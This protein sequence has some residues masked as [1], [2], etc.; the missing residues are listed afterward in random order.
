MRRGYKIS[1]N[2]IGVLLIF[3]LIISASYWKYQNDG[4]HEGATV[5]VEDGLSI[6]FLSGNKISING[7]EKKYAFSVTNNKDTK[8]YYYI[9][10]SDIDCNKEDIRYSL[11]E[12]ENKLNI[13][14]TEFPI[15]DADLASF[16]EIAPG[17]THTYELTLYPEVKT[18]LKANI[19]IRVEDTQKENFAA[20]ILA[21]NE[22]KKEPVTKIGEEASTENEG[23]I[24]AADDNGN[25]YYFRGA[26]SNNYVQFAN[27][28]WRIVK[29]NGDGSIKIILEDY[30]EEKANF[31]DSNSENTIDEKLDFGISNVSATLKN[32]YQLNL[33][34]YEK[35]IATSKYCID[36]SIGQ[37]DGENTY[38]LAYSRLL[39]DYNQVNSCLG[40]KY[41]SRIGL[42]TA[43]EAVF[44]GAS[45]NSENTKF[46]L[47]TEG[48]DHSW[49]T[50]TP[51]SSNSANVTFFE[52]SSNGALKNDSIGSYYRGVK[53]VINLVKNTY[54]SGKGTIEDPYMIRE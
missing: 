40:S 35:Y 51:A 41:N 15:T 29:I 53:P 9:A 31:Y 44:A 27:L 46:Y 36:N 32:W 10:A 4:M 25:A 23:L 12:K 8:I 22:I 13:A 6:N 16:I 45:K 7:E 24:E 43:D 19:I 39:T 11:Q 28:T 1:L 47:Y 54:V 5:F 30:I 33:D 20:T 34:G 37:I 17:D 42:I 52:I 48:K 21:N 49:W 26:V 18:F 50:M 3:L 38:Y 2:I 14:S